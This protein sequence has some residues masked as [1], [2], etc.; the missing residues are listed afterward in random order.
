MADLVRIPGLY[1]VMGYELKVGDMVGFEN[2]SNA[3][4]PETAAGIFVGSQGNIRRVWIGGQVL[5]YNASE[6]GCIKLY[7]K[8][9]T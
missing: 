8:I 2:Q 3:S 6:C 1:G 4:W 9:S 5:E 7:S